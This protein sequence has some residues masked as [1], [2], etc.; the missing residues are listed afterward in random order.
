MTPKTIT[1]II[2]E[3]KER[4]NDLRKMNAEDCT[5]GGDSKSI[6]FGYKTLKGL[7]VFSIVDWGNIEA[8]LR[9]HITALLDHAIAE[10]KRLIE[11][12]KENPMIKDAEE[13][14]GYNK[15]YVDSKDEDI[16]IIEKMK[17]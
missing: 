5:E 9:S 6:E 14:E 8:F 17:L 12:A 11:L 10:K 7:E 1:E 16:Q 15:G 13:Y 2:E 3:F 4:K